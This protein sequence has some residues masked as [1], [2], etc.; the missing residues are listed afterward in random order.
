MKLI[1]AIL[2]IILIC[3]CEKNCPE[4][5]EPNE[6]N[7]VFLIFAEPN[8]SDDV[9]VA[10]NLCLDSNWRHPRE[11][12]QS[13][14]S[15][16][17]K[18]HL[19]CSMYGCDGTCRMC[20]PTNPKW[21]KPPAKPNEV[22]QGTLYD[23]AIIEPSSSMIIYTDSGKEVVIDY[24]GAEVTVIGACE[25]GAKV[26]FEQLLKPICDYYM[27]DSLKDP[28]NVPDGFIRRLAESGRICDVLGHCWRAGRPGEGYDEE[29][30]VALI[31]SD[32][33]PYTNYRTC[34]ICG[35]CQ[36]QDLHWK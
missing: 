24:G 10:I 31:F 3:G 16:L 34:K 2:A 12:S 13:K 29:T 4:P 32:H 26:F 25:E 14:D 19:N 28:N 17:Y 35:I 36:T 27:R 5:N 15:D 21:K 20:D 9:D 18:K 33:H 8:I 22:D 7:D 30:G 23:L 1:P 6:P 11:R